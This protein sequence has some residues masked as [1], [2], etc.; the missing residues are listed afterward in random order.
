MRSSFYHR[1]YIFDPCIVSRV[2]IFYMDLGFKRNNPK[3]CFNNNTLLTCWNLSKN[4]LYETQRFIS[5]IF[6]IILW[7]RKSKVLKHHR[8]LYSFRFWKKLIEIYFIYIVHRPKLK[9]WK[10][11]KSKRLF[12]EHYTQK[13]TYIFKKYFESEVMI[14]KILIFHALSGIMKIL[15]KIFIS[16][17][18]EIWCEYHFS[19]SI[20]SHFK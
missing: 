1:H 20:F 18:L 13:S 8:W 6:T 19:D 17:N 5:K 10:F 2:T 11:I 14:Q 7:V 4:A 9:I 3:T 16:L 12:F 15:K